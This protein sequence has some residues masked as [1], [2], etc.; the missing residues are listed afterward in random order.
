MRTIDN[1]EKEMLDLHPKK[2]LAYM[3]YL[4]NTGNT[5]GL[6]E[7]LW[8][9]FE[10]YCDMWNVLVNERKRLLIDKA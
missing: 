5:S 7:R 1:I 10:R 8:D 3:D 4:D 6:R 9:E 2:E